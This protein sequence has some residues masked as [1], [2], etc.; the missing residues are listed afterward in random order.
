MLKET[1]LLI[2]VSILGYMIPEI[3]AAFSPTKAR[4]TSLWVNTLFAIACVFITYYF[5]G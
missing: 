2:G 4:F 3:I 1:L 5:I